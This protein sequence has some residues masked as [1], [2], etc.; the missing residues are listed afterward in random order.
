M[1]DWLL[2]LSTY[3]TILSLIDRLFLF[4]HTYFCRGSDYP[5]ESLVALSDQS[6][7]YSPWALIFYTFIVYCLEV[8]WRTFLHVSKTYFCRGSSLSDCP[9]E[10]LGFLSDQS[11]VLVALESNLVCSPVFWKCHGGPLVNVLRNYFVGVVNISIGPITGLG[12][13]GQTYFAFLFVWNVLWR[14]R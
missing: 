6:Y 13:G 4:R 3:I 1:A 8:S 7:W 10:S 9:I 2:L 12:F 11:L 14:K 5:I